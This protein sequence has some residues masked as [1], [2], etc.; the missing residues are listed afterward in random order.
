[1]KSIKIILILNGLIYLGFGFFNQV[2]PKTAA[3]LIELQVNNVTSIIDFRATYGGLLIGIGLWFFYTVLK[4]YYILGLI[5]AV[6][7]CAGFLIGRF[8][9]FV[10]DGIP[11]MIQILYLSAEALLLWVMFI[12]LL[13]FNLNFRS[14]D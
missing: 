4:K 8:V 1:M 5:S 10:I 6:F 9:G 12:Q 13:K 3:S 2:Y 14:G 11:N 7:M